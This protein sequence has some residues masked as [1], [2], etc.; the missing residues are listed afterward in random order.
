[1]K[2]KYRVLE[3]DS[4]TKR[5]RI[6]SDN[7][8]GICLPNFVNGKLYSKLFHSVTLLQNLTI[9]YGCKKINFLY[10]YIYIYGFCYMLSKTN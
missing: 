6:V 4:K 2:M 8:D 10:I 9:I 3:M 1:M 5:L 7:M